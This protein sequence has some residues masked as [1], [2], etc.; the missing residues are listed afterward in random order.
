MLNNISGFINGKHRIDSKHTALSGKCNLTGKDLMK[1]AYHA[2]WQGRMIWMDDGHNARFM[3]TSA[4]IIRNEGPGTPRR[5]AK[6]GKNRLGKNN[7]ERMQ[8]SPASI[9]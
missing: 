9:L 3:P 8:E 1:N 4:G 2:L 5:I 6:T 7:V